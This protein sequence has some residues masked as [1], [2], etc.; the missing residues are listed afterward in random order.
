MDTEKSL[1]FLVAEAKKTNKFV[2]IFAG[3]SEQEAMLKEV[4]RL[5][6][7]SLDEMIVIPANP[8][9]IVDQLKDIA[10]LSDVM[11]VIEDAEQLLTLP[12]PR[13]TFK[14][15]AHP[16]EMFEPL[17]LSAEKTQDYGVSKNKKT[18][19]PPK[20]KGFIGKKFQQRGKHR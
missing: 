8:K 10:N 6:S 9:D 14:I 4:C 13:E 3:N 17:M 20:H 1:S 18:F 16:V 19:S 2:V 12:T 5:K 15:H 11:V 7:K